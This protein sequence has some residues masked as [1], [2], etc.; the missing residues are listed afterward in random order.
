[1]H[2]LAAVLHQQLATLPEQGLPGWALGLRQDAA[3]VFAANGLPGTQLEAWKYTSL[4]PLERGVSTLHAAQAGNTPATPASGFAADCCIALVDGRFAGQQGGLAD[5]VE[6]LPMQSALQAGTPGL[7]SLLAGLETAQPAQALAA[8]NT[9]ALLHGVVVRVP[10]GVDAGRLELQ[11]RSSGAA[12]EALGNSR[13]CLLLEAGARLELV[14]HFAADSGRDQVQALNLVLQ[15]ELAERA[16]LTHI[17]LQQGDARDLL[18][19]RTEVDQA[20][21]SEYRH[22]GL[23][24]AGG[25]TRHDLHTRLLGEGAHSEVNGAYLPSGRS[26]VDLQLAIDHRAPNCSSSQFFRGVLKDRGRAVFRG[27]VHVW[28]GA[29]GTEAR[30]SNANLLLS[31]HAEVDTKPE[32]EIEADEVIASHGATVG[33][34][35]EKAVFYLR[36]RGIDE[37]MARQLLTGA[38]C[39]AVIDRLGDQGLRD[40][41]TPQVAAALGEPA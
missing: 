6:L 7:A 38:F 30:Q 20:A 27:R 29:D 12:A 9:A 24:L 36:S 15:A 33:Q 39:Q 22:T 28:P 25:V 8:L 21:G 26:H 4:K 2:G 23:D 11:W 5:G 41:L 35:D 17:R 16:V 14:E 32:L 1:M 18:F 3:G 34:L 40:R 10:A 13:V 19:T 37:A 31:P